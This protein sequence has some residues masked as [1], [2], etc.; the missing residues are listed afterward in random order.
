M[1]R[2]A[3]SSQ[4]S[5]SCEHRPQEGGLKHPRGNPRPS[6]PSLGSAV[7]LTVRMR[8]SWH[9]EVMLAEH[10]GHWRMSTACRVQTSACGMMDTFSMGTGVCR[11]QEENQHCLW[12]GLTPLLCPQ[13]ESREVH[14]AGPKHEPCGRQQGW[15]IW[16]WGS[17]RDAGVPL[18]CIHTSECGRPLWLPPNGPHWGG[19]STC[20]GPS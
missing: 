1:L 14:W 4:L 10:C 3:A 16:P 7:A 9:G 12:L 8:R 20:C 5:P 2:S 18:G 11:E 19:A 13:W 15:E 6:N 17:W